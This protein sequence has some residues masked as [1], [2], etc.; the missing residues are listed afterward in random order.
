MLALP[1]LLVLFVFCFCF[2]NIKIYFNQIFFFTRL[3]GIFLTWKTVQMSA[4]HTINEN[5][6][7]LY[8]W[9]LGSA[10]LVVAKGGSGSRSLCFIE[11]LATSLAFVHEDQ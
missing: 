9:F 4:L 10:I 2:S 3:S 8:H 6:Q 5:F 7:P 11:Y 1:N